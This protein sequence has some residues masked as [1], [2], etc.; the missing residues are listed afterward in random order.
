[1]KI[2]YNWLKQYIDTQLSA[3]ELKTILINLGL[4]VESMERWQSVKGGLGGFI[5]AEV[6]TCQKHPNADKL[7]V[8]TVNTGSGE[9]LQVVCGAP[10]VAAGQKVILATIGTK[11]YSGDEVFEIKKSKIRGEASEGMLCAEDELGLGSSHDGIIVLPDDVKVGTP[12]NQ[13]FNVEDDIVF[14]IGLTPN[15]ID[16][17]SHYGVAR[18]LAAFFNQNNPKKLIKPSVEAFKVDNHNLPIEVVVENQEACIR[19]SG[20]SIS[21]VT[22]KESPDWL[23]NRLNAIGLRPINNIVDVTNFI[24]HELGQPLHAFDAAHIIGNKVVVRTLPQNTEFVTLDGARRKLDANDLMICNTQEGMCIAGVF[25]GEKSGVTVATTKVFIESAC[26]HPVWVRKTARRHGLNTD[27]SFRFERGT[28]PNITVYALKRAALLIQELAGGAI[29]SEIVDIYPKKVENFKVDIT[30]NYID[31]LIGKV[32][33]R[34]RIK[35]ILEG[36]E[37][38]IAS[39]TSEG[40]S[41]LVPPYRVDVQRPADIVEEIIRVYGYNNIEFSEKVISTLGFTERPT[42]EQ[43]Q[44]SISDYLTDNGFNEIMCNSLTASAYYENIEE[45]KNN[46]VKILNPLSSDLNCMRQ[47][48]IYGALESIVLNINRKQNNL[49]MYEFGNTYF[50][51]AN[52]GEGLKKYNEKYHLGLFVTGLDQETNWNTAKEPVGFF[53]LKG[54]VNNLLI[55]AGVNIA[56]VVAEP[57]NHPLISNGLQYS[58]NGKLLAVLGSIKSAVL[59][60]FDIKQEVFAAEVEWDLVF[61]LAKKKKV[62]YKEL[63][64]F[65][66]VKR[67]LSMILDMQVTYAQIEQLAYKTER[68]LL[69]NVNLFDVYQGDKIEQGKKSYALSF[70]LQDEEKT[71]TDNQIDKV[72]QNLIK[73]YESQLGAKVRMQL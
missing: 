36:L 2:S 69:K 19:Y 66:E 11:I 6:L 48:L 21:G 10:N 73:A 34:D 33:D 27:S 62:E 40:L 56:Q 67:D 18:D 68:K 1:M 46:I 22:V 42:A 25:G 5:I 51:D 8:T 39:E 37:I 32:I 4:E 14:E 63:P 54:Y 20:V 50:F 17:A 41:L 72:M 23:K 38:T 60:S 70:I 13:Y 45:Y 49:K 29:S 28:D 65:P 44:N 3:E 55:K 30:Y 57:V 52:K 35:K 43:L 7:S 9:P 15:R 58:I 26:F 16:C 12:A 61:S 71:L 47:T 31:T 64:K 53:H 59:K 24:L